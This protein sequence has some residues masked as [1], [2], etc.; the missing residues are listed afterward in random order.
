MSS[1]RRSR[2]LSTLSRLRANPNPN[3]NSNSLT[4]QAGI[5]SRN[6]L[7]SF[8][9]PSFQS[10]STRTDDDSDFLSSESPSELQPIK[11][12]LDAV[13]EG[14]VNGSRVV[15]ESILPVGAVISLLDSFHDLT[16]LPWWIIITSSTLGGTLWFQNLTEFP[17][18]GLASIFPLLIAGL[19]YVNVQK[20]F[21]EAN[22][23]TFLFDLF[24]E[25][26]SYRSENIRLETNRKELE[27]ILQLRA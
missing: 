21:N 10:F 12:E 3:S 17:H 25:N 24:R 14:V 22:E 9:F 13:T 23:G 8:L 1:L 4:S 26:N 7:A 19:H 16:G 15:E 11:F 2:L 6:S 27:L 18:G 5:P 20:W